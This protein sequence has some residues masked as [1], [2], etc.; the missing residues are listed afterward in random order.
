[1]LKPCQHPSERKKS[2]R[3]VPRMKATATQVNRV[4]ISAFV[5]S[6]NLG[7]E[8]IFL[9]FID[10]LKNYLTKPR[11]TVASV[12]PAKTRRL[13]ISQDS[14]AFSD[15][16]V[17]SRLTLPLA[18][19]RHRVCIFGGGGIIQDLSSVFNLIYFLAQIQFAKLTGKI[20]VLAFVGIGPLTSSVGRTLTRH[21]LSKIELCIVRDQDSKRMLEELGVVGTEIIS[22]SDIALNLQ[23]KPC[24]GLDI[25]GRYVLLSL[26]H[27]YNRSNSVTPASFNSGDVKPGTLLDAFLTKVARELG[28]ILQANED[29]YIVAV[30]FFGTRDEV[31]HD[32]L[33]G[34]LDPEFRQRLRHV[35]EIVRPCQYVGLTASAA[36]VVGMRLHSL[37]L[38]SIT[39]APLLGLSYAPK[40]KSFMRQLHLH[41]QVIDVELAPHVDDLAE[42]LSG[43]LSNSE[44]T[45]EK[46]VRR[47]GEL[48]KL[49]TAALIRLLEIIGNE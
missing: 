27:L 10:Q 49:N 46:L 14:N 18:I 34:K 42:K 15:V 39:G 28:T 23:C 9:S 35:R 5:G 8:A 21:A 11:L 38:A 6:K 33:S 41:E 43:I 17:V 1:M 25:D 48:Q 7:D 4:L 16:K 44:Q 30:S 29:L 32:A 24:N 37:V 45:K 12:D 47:V 13:L 2:N 36:C 22:A 19:F 40:V 31:V 20:V 26:R 3:H